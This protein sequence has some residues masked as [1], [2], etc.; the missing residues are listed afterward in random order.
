MLDFLTLGLSAFS[1]WGNFYYLAQLVPWVA[2]SLILAVLF[3]CFGNGLGRRFP[4][5]GLSISLYY[6]VMWLT[7]MSEG[8]IIGWGDLAYNLIW[9]WPIVG[10]LVGIAASA[11]VEKVFSPRAE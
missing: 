2:S 9:L 11:I 8:Y 3:Y 4:F 6:L 7:F 1:W 10:F 5:S